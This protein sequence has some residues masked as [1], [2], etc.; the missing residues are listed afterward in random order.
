MHLSI[1]KNVIKTR[2]TQKMKRT[3][4]LLSLIPILGSVFYSLYL[5]TKDTR[6]FKMSGLSLLL[7]MLAFIII[8]GGFAI[9]CNTTALNLANHMW[10]VALFFCISGIAWNF[11]YFITLNKM[12]PN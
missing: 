11:T 2:E 12:N 7:G 1:N 10:L 8:Y 5:F 3:Q 4:I 9:I 6:K